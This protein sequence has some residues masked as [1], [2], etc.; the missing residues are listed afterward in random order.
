MTVLSIR[1]NLRPQYIYRATLTKRGKLKHI[2]AGCRTWRT[3]ES[4]FRHY[5]SQRGLPRWTDEQIE[6]LPEKDMFGRH[7]RRREWA[8]RTE[9]RAILRRLADNTH[10]MQK[11]MLTARRNQRKGK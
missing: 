4:A 8:E 10:R 1:S 11:A 3:W 2:V 9:A 6:A 5:H 7:R